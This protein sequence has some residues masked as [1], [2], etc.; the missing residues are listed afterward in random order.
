MGFSG[1]SADEVGPVALVDFI[2]IIVLATLQQID[3]ATLEGFFI[4]HKARLLENTLV[5]LKCELVALMSLQYV[6]YFVS[7]GLLLK[8]LS[9]N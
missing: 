8:F 2:K 7:I 1:R 3:E 9:N 5:S 6:Q 4:E